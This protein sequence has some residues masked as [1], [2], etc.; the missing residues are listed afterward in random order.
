VCNARQ[1]AFV[2]ATTIKKQA[3]PRIPEHSLMPLQIPILKTLTSFP[4]CVILGIQE[5][6]PDRPVVSSAKVESTRHLT[7]QMRVLCVLLESIWKVLQPHLSLLV[8]V[9]MQVN[10]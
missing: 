2:V 5:M 4:A 3:A 7:E 1:T 8:S 6:L 10:F 9:V